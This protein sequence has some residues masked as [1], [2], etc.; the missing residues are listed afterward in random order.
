M[1]TM[2][3]VFRPFTDVYNLQRVV[4]KWLFSL[5]NVASR[6]GVFIEEWNLRLFLI[7]FQ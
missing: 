3:M 6:G 4:I 1:Y 7:L 2:Y 5:S